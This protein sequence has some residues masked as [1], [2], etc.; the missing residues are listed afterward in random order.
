MENNTARTYHSPIS[1][2][3]GEKITIFDKFCDE[4]EGLLD[5]HTAKE[6]HNMWILTLCYLLHHLYFRKEVLPLVPFG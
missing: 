3:V 1:S 4:A 2:E 6:T 5:C